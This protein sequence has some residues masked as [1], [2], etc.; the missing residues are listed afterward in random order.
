VRPRRAARDPQDQRVP[1]DRELNRLQPVAFYARL[2]ATAHHLLEPVHLGVHAVG[3]ETAHV[4]RDATR[5]GDAVDEVRSVRVGEGG[6]LGQERRCLECLGQYDPGLVAIE[7]QGQLDDPGYIV[8][9]LPPKQ[10]LR[11]NQNVFAFSL[12]AASLEV[13]QFLS[14]IV[15]P[16]GVADPGEQ[17]YHFVTGP[18]RR[19]AP[20][21]RSRPK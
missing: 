10:P 6:D 15:A 14:M 20:P 3:F 18:R 8:E 5:L 17:N 4:L 12:G 1:P 7:Q 19:S 2:Y 16:S 21:W 9:G 13:L 11:G